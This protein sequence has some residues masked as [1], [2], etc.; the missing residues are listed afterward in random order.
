MEEKGRATEARTERDADALTGNSADP[1]LMK[2][3]FN[4]AYK[5]SPVAY[6]TL[7]K[8][9]KEVQKEIKNVDKGKV[10]KY[11]GSQRIFNQYSPRPKMSR[12]VTRPVIR[13]QPWESIACDLL[14]LIGLSSK[15]KNFKYV[16]I[17]ID[18]LSKYLIAIPIRSKKEAEMKRGFDAAF[19]DKHV[20]L[21]ALAHAW[22]D[23]GGEFIGISKWLRDKYHLSQYSTNTG[24]RKSSFVENVIRELEKRLFRRLD[25]L[26]SEKWIDELDTVVDQYNRDEQPS[27]LNHSPMYIYTFGFRGIFVYK[28]KTKFKARL[29]FPPF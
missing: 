5:N 10:E 9:F 18:F 21:D 22:N 26:G 24:L 12:R 7:K 1:L 4:K 8:L 17:I 27:L 13:K 28:A 23:R 2:A 20:R 25:A 14:T 11:I 15:N 3:V 6:S 29:P 16:L 19:A